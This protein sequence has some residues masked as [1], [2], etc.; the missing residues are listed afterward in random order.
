MGNLDKLTQEEARMASAELLKMAHIVDNKVMGVDDRV[1]GV[2]GRVQDVCDD[3]HDVRSDVQDVG[4]KVES[5]EGRVQDVRDDVQDVG[6]KVQD[7]DHRVQSVGNNI[8]SRVQGVDDKI[9]Q[10][11]RSSFVH[12]LLPIS[13]THASQGPSSEKI[14]YDGFHPQIHPPIITL[15]ATLIMTVQLNGF[16]KEVYSNSGNL[17]D[18]SYGYTENVRYLAVTV[19]YFL[20]ISQFFSGIRQKYPLVCRSSTFSAAVKLT[21]SI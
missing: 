18:L 20:I 10:V 7:I 14:F 13:S 4:N 15:L 3:V 9:D 6:N 11:N 1:K 17:L 2:E 16:F 8:S 12:F 5:V 19:H 21:S